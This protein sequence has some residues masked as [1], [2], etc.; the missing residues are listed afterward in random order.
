ML[1]EVKAEDN[2]TEVLLII[3]LKTQKKWFNAFLERNRW[4]V[5]SMYETGTKLFS[6]PSKPN[7]FYIKRNA[8]VQSIEPIMAFTAVAQGKAPQKPSLAKQFKENMERKENGYTVPIRS[9]CSNPTE[10]RPE[11]RHR[12]N[13]KCPWCNSMLREDRKHKRCE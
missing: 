11:D 7:V 9:F 5:V 3:P 1:E 10:N 13:Y 2:S 12:Y 4:K 8:V 6:R